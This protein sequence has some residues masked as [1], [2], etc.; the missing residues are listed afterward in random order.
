MQALYVMQ[1]TGVSLATILTS[2]RRE[3]LGLDAEGEPVDY[4]D[5]ELFRAVLEGVFAN[6]DQVD[7]AIQGCLKVG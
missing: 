5:P 4:T 1:Q 7:A 6:Q 2:Y 3:E